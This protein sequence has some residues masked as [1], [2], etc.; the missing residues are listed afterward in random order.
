[1][2]AMTA[3]ALNSDR[4]RCFDAGMDGFVSK[5]VHKT[6]LAAEIARVVAG[7]PHT[8]EG[9]QSDRSPVPGSDVVIDEQKLMARVG[10][11]FDLAREVIDLFFD[12]YPER[13][14]EIQKA[15]QKGDCT[16]VQCSAH[17]IKGSVAS[18]AARRAF[19]TAATIEEM[20]R[21]GD[22]PGIRETYPL[23]EADLAHL[24]QALTEIK[25]KLS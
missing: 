14:A 25:E 13:L 24:A 23:L 5:P 6:D 4:E 12:D 17:V 18:L 8:T 20:A 15:I 3:H 2:I 22:E 11:K 9:R 19:Q 1:M 16:S 7:T 10:G 21:A